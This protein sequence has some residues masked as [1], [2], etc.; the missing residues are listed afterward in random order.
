MNASI[1]PPGDRET[2]TTGFL[3]TP[4]REAEQRLRQS[5]YLALRDVTCT[6]IDGVVHL[7]GRLPSYYLKQIAQEVASGVEGVGH[8]VNRIQ[9]LAPARLDGPSNILVK[10]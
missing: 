6:D 1:C 10:G 9:V 8:V 5:S 7:G 3:P 4:G 2:S